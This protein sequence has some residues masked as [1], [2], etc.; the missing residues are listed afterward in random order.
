MERL[1]SEH[2]IQ[3]TRGLEQSKR[4][5]LRGL[6]DLDIISHLTIEDEEGS[7]LLLVN[8]VNGYLVRAS[9]TTGELAEGQT[10]FESLLKLIEERDTAHSFDKATL[11]Q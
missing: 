3:I 8:T 11:V 10:G 6:I 4:D 7:V 2:D 9:I 1:R 5:F